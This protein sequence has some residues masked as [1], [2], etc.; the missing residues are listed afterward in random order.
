MVNRAAGLLAS[1]IRGDDPIVASRFIF[2]ADGM[3]LGSFNE[4]SGL[5]AEI[6]VE[7]IPEGGQNEFIHQRPS[8]IRWNNITLRRGV[9]DSEG[10]YKWFK[11]S[12]GEKFAGNGDKFKPLHC[13]I[14]T[15]EPD[16][17]I[18]RE[19]A[20]TDAFPVRW[21]GPTLSADA[22]DVAMEELEIAHHGLRTSAF[23]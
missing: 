10:M 17:G 1:Y 23:I 19:W 21:T 12:S 18:S 16:G 22:T 5:G 6:E 14:L 4:V 7:T 11:E 13:V 2:A 8:G 3:W 20:V 15:L 9:T